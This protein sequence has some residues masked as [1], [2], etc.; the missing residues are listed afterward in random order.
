MTTATGSYA[1]TAGIKL[2]ANI[3]DTTDD[4]LLGTIADQVNQY[5]ES[6]TKRILAPISSAVYLYDGDGS[7]R[8]FLPLTSDDTPIGGVRAVTK[9]EVAQYTAGAYVEIP[10]TDYFLR[11][12]S[13]PA[14]PFDWLY[15]TD[16]PTTGYGC[17]PHGFNTVRV[18]AT[19][20]W[21]AIPDDIIDV[22]LTTAVRA[23]HAREAGQQD[24][25]GTDEFGRP[26]VSRFLSS[27]DMNTL[28]R[29]KMGRDL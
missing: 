28:R 19:A 10:S 4:T 22:A 27:K 25:V 1:T 9:L 17:F 5:I 20:G 26:I 16:R 15:L 2:R 3:T 8:L 14:A 12:K 6:E 11:G 18:T 21:A 13:L 29:F 23:W 7:R 24:I